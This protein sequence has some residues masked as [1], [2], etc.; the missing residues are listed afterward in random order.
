MNNEFLVLDDNLQDE[1]LLNLISDKDG[2]TPKKNRLNIINIF[3]KH[4]FHFELDND[5]KA[6]LLDESER[7]LILA[8]AGGGK[9]T[10]L[11]IKAILE[12]I[13]RQSKLHEGKIRGDNMLFLVYN[14][15]NVNDIKKKHMELVNSI[16][17]SGLKGVE[18]LD[19]YVSAST[20]H[21]FCDSWLKEYL[22]EA[23]MFNYKLI[24]GN[25]VSNLM[26]VSCKVA[27]K[28]FNMD[29]DMIEQYGYEEVDP[30][31]INSS[32]LL[33]IYNKM[34]ESCDDIYCIEDYDT[35]KSLNV[36]LEFVS[37]VFEK[38]DRAKVMK[39]RYDFT[40]MLIKFYELISGAFDTENRKVSE[41]VLKRIHSRYEYMTVD[42]Y[43]DFTPIQNKILPILSDGINLTCIGDD[44]QAIYEFRGADYDNILSFKDNFP[45]S[46]IM[47]LKTNRRCPA[48]VIH[49]CNDIIQL[50]KK[51]Y[52]KDMRAIKPDGLITFKGY[53]ERRTEIISICNLIESFD[54]TKRKNTV[55]C[56]RNK[57]Q[58]REL[59]EEFLKRGIKYH[60]LSG[61]NPFDYGLFKA[62]TE[63]LEALSVFSNKR[64]FLNLYKCLPITR[65]ELEELLGYNPKTDTFSDGELGSL[66]ECDFSS[67]LNNSKFVESIKILIDISS[68]MS[69]LKCSDYVIV[70]LNMIKKFYWDYQ[71][72]IRDL[73]RN[74]DTQ[75]TKT[76]LDRFNVDKPYI[77]VESILQQDKNSLKNDQVNKNG[78]CLSTM[79]SLKGLE[80]DNVIIM[81]MKESL[82]NSSIDSEV[83]LCFVGMTRTKK[84]LY[85]FYDKNDP[86]VIVTTGV[87][88][89]K[90]YK[91]NSLD[92]LVIKDELKED[93]I[94]VLDREEKEEEIR[95]NFS[96]RFN[97]VSEDNNELEIDYDKEYGDEELEVE[98]E[99][100][101]STV[102]L[103]SD[104][105]RTFFGNK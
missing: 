29:E 49:M 40:D 10:T 37:L 51:R 93:D 26:K 88:S 34:K 87:E 30:N 64:L 19:D 43:Q 77:Y 1:D 45:N 47:L 11:N 25:E 101:F 90:N 55:I 15:E 20:M 4:I 66:V 32:K 41:E 3:Y 94:S 28:H 38:F 52:P 63:V 79:H 73:D 27:S 78:V 67:K 18:N 74:L 6:C 31:R 61:V 59:I 2:I 65:V 16:K 33:Q 86:S 56:Y 9:T 21:S 23:N 105:M 57:E 36:P 5:L 84:E 76:I 92:N 96:S 71:V 103:K 85:L 70:L 58:S 100:K 48:N 24:T 12:K 91:P 95:M 53:S 68:N 98:T 104:L 83:R 99:D 62:L 8:T 82:I 54:D 44:D 42:E 89:L 22:L 60:T 39:K 102:D 81:D 35:F 75:I 69:T 80:Y 14:S 7:L 17:D 46:K 72:K 13:C 50:N 97:D